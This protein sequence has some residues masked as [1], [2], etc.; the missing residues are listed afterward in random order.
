MAKREKNPLSE[1]SE[2]VQKDFENDKPIMSFAAFVELLLATPDRFARSS[3]QYIHDCFDYFGR[4][5][6]ETFLG[7]FERFSLFDAPF[8]QGRNAV[9]GHHRV[10]ERVFRLIEGFVRQ[11]RVN[12][13]IVLHGPNGSAKSTFV[14]VMMRGLEAYSRTEEGAIYRFNWVFPNERKTSGSSIGF[15]GGQ[16]GVDPDS[17]D[18]YALLDADQIDARIRS[19]LNDH[20][21]LLIPS[22]Q[23]LELLAPLIEKGAHFTE[24]IL[25][26]DLSHSS[27]QIF[28]TLMSSY[29]GDFARVLK[30]IQVERFYFSKRYRVGLVTV[31]PQMRVDAGLRQITM[32]RS[33]SQL[34]AILQNVTLLE[35]F[36]DL[37]DANRGVITYDDMFKRH[38]DLNKYLLGTSEKA[39]VS[40][41]NRILHL[42]TVLVATA[43]EDYLEAYK[44]TPDYVS[45]KGRVELVRVPYILDYNL[46]R[47][48]YD[49]HLKSV[50]DISHV[51]PHTSHIAALWAVLT[52]LKRPRADLYPKSLR[53]VINQLAPLEKAELYA[54]GVL[55]EYV[56][57]DRGRELLRIIP[58]LLDEG[59]GTADYEGRY[60]A[61]PREMK[62]I[63][64]SASQ[65]P[66]YDYLSPLAVLEELE[67]LVKDPSVFPFLQMKPD[68]D[69][70][71]H[72]NFVQTVRER[73]VELVDRE[74]L[75]ALGLV[76]AGQYDDL[77]ARYVDHVSQRL[78]GE[79]VFN[80]STNQYEDPSEKFLGE[81]E[82]LF[83]LEIED[84][85]GFRESIISSIAA[86]SIDHPGEK[87]DL[88]RIFPGLF[89]SMRKKF[90]EER[91]G[92]VGKIMEDIVKLSHE[93][94]H[95]SAEEVKVASKAIESL[96][97]K[98]GYRK[99]S[100]EAAV[101][102]LFSS[103][104][105]R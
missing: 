38:P 26:G 74:V 40:L 61:S 11:G 22:S 68:G 25:Y 91:Q 50:P 103:R 94:E 102:F 53:D 5:K 9:I 45:F 51:A 15:G 13:L 101:A 86:Y 3:A 14:D 7:A 87:M 4:T 64:V 83:G 66:D 24:H 36:G 65:H 63:M 16:R 89:A 6:Q 23:R 47:R 71:R 21:L 85:E 17:L 62:M 52:R 39:T 28:D 1:I 55:P 90:F 72:D 92:T 82:E 19:D 30:H 34:P 77:F 96:C 57:P 81:V 54:S 67:L 33:A 104:Y 31:E 56:P 60:G 20:P 32:D 42:D 99:D 100:A 105:K 93:D 58:D 75:D 35:P 79:K 48:I 95:L 80:K 29:H 2:R 98:Y 8:E 10:Q 27:R 37:P 88:T 84:P 49:E 44:Q 41:D 12:K 70:F 78:K 59:E 69:Y 46:E 97:E 18:S 43:N 76:D 73:Y